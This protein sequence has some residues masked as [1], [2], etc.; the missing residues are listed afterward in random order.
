MSGRIWRILSESYVF[1]KGIFRYK[2]IMFWVV[3]FPL[4]WYGLMVAIWGSPTANPVSVGVYCEDLPVNG[5]SLGSQLVKAMKD[6]GIFIVKEY[7]SLAELESNI[8]KGKVSAGLYIPENFTRD[9]FTGVHGKLIVYTINTSDG[10]I[11]SGYLQGFLNGFA[12]STREYYI[13][14]SISF[15]ENSTM[16]PENYTSNAIRWLEFIKRPIIIQENNYTPPL[17]AT[18]SGIKAFYAISM[19]GVESLFVGLFTGV[20]SVIERKQQGTLRVLLSN[21][22][23]GTDILLADI[24]SSLLAVSLSALAVFGVSLLT[25]ARYVGI[26]ITAILVI[27][28]LLFIGTIFST[29]IGL[30]IAPLARSPEGAGILANAIAWPVMFAG[31]I[32]IPV[33]ILP[34]WLRKFAEYWPLSDMLNQVRGILL[35]NLPVSQALYNS[36]GAIVATIVVLLIGVKVYRRMLEKA[37]EL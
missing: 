13:N 2:E 30:L 22:I 33:E 28:T 21:P 24:V 35:Y 37:V 26:S 9:L 20:N 31:G 29:A 17:I 23:S 7:N 1:I 27:V 8:N 12:D 18:S 6:S 3:L 36:I 32:V 16:M 19:V 15:I 14:M 25:G 10:R 34:V 5:T 11:A 4:L